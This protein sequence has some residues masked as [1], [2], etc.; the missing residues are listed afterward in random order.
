MILRIAGLPVSREDHARVS[1]VLR[2]TQHFD[3]LRRVRDQ[4]R[5]R[6][7]DPVRV[8]KHEKKFDL[9]TERDEEVYRIG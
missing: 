5:L 6:T 2:A 3:V 8:L 4:G 9:P 1:F 7:F